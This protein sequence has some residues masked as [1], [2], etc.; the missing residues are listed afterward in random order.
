MLEATY[1]TRRPNEN[2]SNILLSPGSCRQD[3]EEKHQ[4]D[5]DNPETIFLFKISE[6]TNPSSFSHEPFFENAH[7]RVYKALEVIHSIFTPH[8]DLRNLA[9]LSRGLPPFWLPLTK[10]LSLSLQPLTPL[11]QPPTPL[12]LPS[13]FSASLS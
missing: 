3:D 8:I 7:R 10:S 11:S 1:D 12:P 5:D 4:P 2:P 13:Y 6:I 9:L